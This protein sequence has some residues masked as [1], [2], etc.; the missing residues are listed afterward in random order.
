MPIFDDS[1]L[2]SLI[3]EGEIEISRQIRLIHNRIAIA[4]TAGN[5]IYSLPTNLIG[6]RRVT[7]K[8]NELPA[9]SVI[10]MNTSDYFRPQNL[11]NQTVPKWFN[12][13]N[14]N[15]E[16][17]QILPVPNESLVDTGDLNDSEIIKERFIITGIFLAIP[18]GTTYRLPEFMR[19]NVIKFYAM[20]EA[21]LREGKGQNLTASEYFGNMYSTF[22]GIYKEIME[23]IPR[24]VR[25]SLE[26]N[27][28]RKIA[29]PQL[30]TT[31]KW[32]F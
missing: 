15:Y 29:R 32:S 17:I 6:I 24:A 13:L 26:P 31:G 4:T 22:L 11:M 10:E 28:H 20:R 19:R 7:W 23:A 2:Q 3:D 14:N 16:K 18:T 8:G 9:L 21:Y 5:S 12:P 1:Y 30:P 27:Q 25:Y